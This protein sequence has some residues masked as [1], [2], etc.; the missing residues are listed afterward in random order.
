MSI[1]AKQYLVKQ[2]GHELGDTLSANDLR[3]VQERLNDILSMYEVEDLEG[4]QI[5]GE[6][7]DLLNAFLDAKEIEGRSPKTLEHYR[8]IITRMMQELNV[9]IRRITV[10]HLRSYLMKKKANGIQDKTLEGERSVLCSY[11]GWLQKEGLLPANPCANLAP[12]KCAKK[13]RTPY[14]EVD[15]ERLKEACWCNG[16]KAMISFLLS[17]GCRISEV[18]G[19]NRD[20][21]DFITGEC[22]V[23]GKGN[24]E[25][26]VFID[27]VTA[28]LLQRYLSE[29]TDSSEALFAGKG[30]GRMTPGGI[31]ARL[32]NIA[33]KADI[34]NVHPH[35]FRR[36]LATNLIDRGMKIQEVA[37]ILGHDKLDTTMKYVYID[38]SNVKNAYRKF[39]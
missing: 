18:C 6:S 30:T 5:D 7:D 12:I 11:F 29:R 2:I 8:Y 23:L 3:L 25:R 31:R 26:T 19:L 32:H 24:K 20:S 14:S 21:V 38:K 35:R 36:T 33:D 28:M 10:F 34:A 37:S 17:T 4:V 16:D 9:P 22:T 13:V 39:I 1:T 27:D 15:I